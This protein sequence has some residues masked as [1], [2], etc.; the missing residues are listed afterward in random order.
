MLWRNWSNLGVYWITAS[1]VDIYGL[2]IFVSVSI[3]FW[4]DIR[5]LMSRL[6]LF[7]L[8]KLHKYTSVKHAIAGDKLNP[9]TI[10]VQLQLPKSPVSPCKIFG[11][12][13][14]TPCCTKPTY[15]LELC[16][17]YQKTSFSTINCQKPFLKA[18]EYIHTKQLM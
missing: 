17:P 2:N 1:P 16:F 9:I 11:P 5:L 14:T 6:C 3:N 18:E 4:Q 12:K 8:N 15:N 10:V 7:L 13:V